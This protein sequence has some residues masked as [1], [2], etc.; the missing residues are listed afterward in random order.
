MIKASDLFEGENSSLMRTWEKAILEA[1]E[2]CLTCGEQMSKV[3][4]YTYT[5]E[6]CRPQLF[7]SIG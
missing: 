7:I 1:P 5:C 6:K 3:D 4:E 2:I